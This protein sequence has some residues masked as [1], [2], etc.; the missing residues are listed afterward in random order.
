MRI[1]GW[2]FLAVCHHSDKSCDHKH[3]FSGDIFLICRVTSR[4]HMF[5]ELC[6][7][8]MGAP[9]LRHTCLEE[10]LTE[11]TYKTFASPSRKDDEKGKRNKR[12]EIEWQLQ[13]FLR[14]ATIIKM[15]SN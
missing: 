2:E 6:E 1:C 11:I 7:L 12:K 14:C 13:S 8:W 10:Q 3:C 4:E 9:D 5:K 15:G